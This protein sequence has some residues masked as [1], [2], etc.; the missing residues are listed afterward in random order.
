MTTLPATIFA[1]GSSARPDS[2]RTERAGLVSVGSVDHEH[3]D[4]VADQLLG[5]LG[6]ITVDPDC[7]TDHQAALRIDGR[8]VD[9][10]TK[11]ALTGDH[12]EQPTVIVHDGSNPEPV[13]AQMVERCGRVDVGAEDVQA[14]SSSSRWPIA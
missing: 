10:R 6:G 5:V 14:S 1:S 4:A 13:A 8:V 7:R 11:R 3:V 9:R 2:D 12:T